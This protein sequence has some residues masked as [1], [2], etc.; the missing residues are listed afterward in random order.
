MWVLGLA[1]MAVAALLSDRNPPIST[2]QPPDDVFS[3][4]VW[5]SSFV[6]FG[7]VGALVVSSRPS[8]RIGWILS[9]ITFSV[10]VGV[11]A[12]AYGRY[13]LVTAPG[14]LPLGRS[15][16]WLTGWG[17]VVPVTLAV[18]LV[19]LYPTGSTTSIMG[20]FV[21]RAFLSLAALDAV[22]YALRPGPVEG[23]TPP[24]NPLGIPGANRFLS[25]MI[26]FLGIALA[27]LFIAGVFDLFVRF[28][29]SRG[30]E[31]QQ[32]RWFFAAFAA[33]PILFVLGNLLEEGIPG[34]NG[35]DPM[36]VIFPLWGIGTATAIAVA[37]TRH[38]LYEID[39]IISRTV[40]YSVVVALLGAVYVVGVTLLTSLLPEQSQLVVAA[41]TLAV[42]AL[43]NPVR[44]RV[45]VGVD[46][47]FNR[48][49]YDTQRV[50]ARFADSLRDQ[51]DS[52]KVVQGWVG[53]VSDTMQPA[54]VGV[55]V[56]K[57]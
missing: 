21:T 20:R 38:G 51:V 36:V 49:R 43:F 46:R 50:M 7:V 25:P 42:A 3:G 37:I 4:I 32:F 56:R 18:V 54:T 39:R 47:R 23:D 30:S 13:A 29:R 19:L 17:V 9:G 33:F 41:I 45:Q 31:R 14:T 24:N 22:A 44:R 16:A 53:V 34:W 48:S 26:S 10:G 57:G 11:F 35:F 2:I 40:S 15:A 1:G 28:R 12:A 6:G 52:E 55:W 8:N 27:L 5:L